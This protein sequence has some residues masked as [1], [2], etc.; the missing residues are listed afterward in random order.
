MGGKLGSPPNILVVQSVFNQSFRLYNDSFFHLVTDN[1][2]DH[3][4]FHSTFFHGSLTTYPFV[5]F[6]FDAGT[7]LLPG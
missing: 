4:S 7:A 1:D 5:G 6:R 3:L 2:A